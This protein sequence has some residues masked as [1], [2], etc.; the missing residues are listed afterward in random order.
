MN[1]SK[2]TTRITT[3]LVNTEESKVDS[4]GLTLIKEFQ[5]QVVQVARIVVGEQSHDDINVPWKFTL[6]SG[7]E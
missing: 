7:N 4:R 6:H 2:L 3:H 1:T 5:E